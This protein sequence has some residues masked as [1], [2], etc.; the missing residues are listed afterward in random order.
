MRVSFSQRQ[1]QNERGVSRSHPLL[2]PKQVPSG[3]HQ[4][5]GN[6]HDLS[7]YPANSPLCTDDHQLRQTRE[8]LI[9]LIADYGV[10][11]LS[12][13]EVQQRLLRHFADATIVATPVPPFDTIGAGFCVAQLGLN[14]GPSERIVYHN[15]APRRDEAGP[16]KG[17][18]GER[19]VKAVLANGTL[20]IGTD[21]QYAFSF[22][23]DEATLL[24]EV[25][26][27]AHGSQFRSRDFFPDLIAEVVN[28]GADDGPILKAEDFPP[29]PTATV[30]FTDAFGNI[31]TTIDTAP[32]P[33][34]T[35][36]IVRLGDRWAK[37]IVAEG[38]FEVATGELGLVP[39][40]SGWSLQS[41]GKRTWW[42]LFERGASAAERF[43]QPRSGTAVEVAP[44]AKTH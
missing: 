2:S 5:T 42:E 36:L 43:G 26:I 35:E 31:K 13:A 33:V 22:I 28:G 12:F 6:F 25:P 8:V 37:G 20:V 3:Y 38:A 23:R 11:D 29:V 9:H 16:R 44:A 4:P 10:G 15:V 34:G 18:T 24:Q 41:G 32:A 21:S 27:R 40:S 7:R 19:L 39:G 17:N 1:N 30:A 14:D